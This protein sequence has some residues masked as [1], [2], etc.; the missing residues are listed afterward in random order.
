MS[1]V[2]HKLEFVYLPS[3]PF[4]FNIIYGGIQN[5]FTGRFIKYDILMS[6]K[7]INTIQQMH[8]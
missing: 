8:R 1:T 7:E 3:F 5:Y 2:T 6:L 4:V